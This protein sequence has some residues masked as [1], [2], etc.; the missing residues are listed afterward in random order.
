MNGLADGHASSTA[1]KTHHPGSIVRVTLI[2]FV[3]YTK[4]EFN[5]G[6]NLNMVIGPNGTGKST[7]VCAICIGLGWA[8]KHLGR[9][10]DLDEFVKHGANKAQIEIELA[11]DPERHDRNPVI[12]TK[13][14]KG[15]TT[16]AEYLINGK[17]ENKKRVIE[18]ARSFSIQ[19]DNLCQFLPQDRVSEFAGLS[20]VELLTETQRAAAPEY[21]TEWHEQLKEWRKAQKTQQAEQQRLTEDIKKQEDRQRLQEA[22]VQ[23]LR[24]R[25]GLQDRVN[26]L[27]KMRALPEYRETKEA[28][29]TAK[30]ARSQAHSEL[31]RLEQRMQ[32]NLEAVT[33]KQR[34]REL[35]QKVLPSQ[36]R[37]VE[38]TEGRAD[39]AKKKIDEADE[40]MKECKDRIEAERT[41]VRAVKQSMPGLQRNV[42][43]IQ[44]ALQNPP[45]AFDPTAM[46]EEKRA[47]ERQ[48]RDVND[49][50]QEA[51][52]E[53]D[54]L[55]QQMRQRTAIV[56][57]AKQ[58]KLDL[59]SQA[60]KN[61]NKVKSFSPDSA[62]AWEWIQN[63]RNRFRGEVY[64][65]PLVECRVKDPKF[66][67]AVES[68]I[69]QA[70]ALSFTVTTKADFDMLTEQLYRTLRLNQVSIRASLTGLDTYRAPMPTE[71]LRQYGLQG[72]ILDLLEGPEPVLAMLCDNRMI[73]KAAYTL[74]K[75]SEAQF[76]ALQQSQINSWVT[77]Q[78]SYVIT[79][80]REYGD[81]ATSTRVQD[82]R[83]A[84]FF[85][86]ITIDHQQESVIDRRIAE[87]QSEIDELGQSRLA[88]IKDAETLQSQIKG[89]TEERDAIEKEKRA[90][91]T[92]HTQFGALPTKLENAK[93]K[94]TEARNKMAGF[95]ERKA[96][97]E[98][99]ED[100]LSLQKGQFA[101]DYANL[102]ETLRGLH[103]QVFEAEIVQ[104][105]ADS[106]LEQIRAQ[107]AEE[108]RLLN[109]KKAE[110]ERLRTRERELL[111]AGQ[112]L[113]QQCNDMQTDFTDEERAIW[114]E[115]EEWTLEQW[116]TEVVSVNARLESLV[117]GGNQNTL[118]EFEARKAQIE[119]M[120]RK[121]NELG[122][123][124]EE[125]DVQ[126]TD[127]RERWEPEL[128]A[129]VGEISEAFAENFSKIQSAGEVGVYKAEDFEDW[130]I[131]IQVKFRYVSKPFHIPT[132][133][134]PTNTPLTEKTNR[135][136]SS[137]P[138]ANPA[139]SAPSAPSSTSWRCKRS[140]ARPSASS[141]RS[142]RAWT[143]ATSASCTRAWSTSRARRPA[144]AGRAAST[145]SSRPN[146]CRGSSITRI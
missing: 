7:L 133:S 103:L 86:D 46:N 56:Q 120:T 113:R 48:I 37:L 79:R 124:L 115:I 141:T 18:L 32:P 70:D 138:T 8:T 97:I 98:R 100:A 111:R 14:K 58:Q 142:T 65:P 101:L 129:L 139:A 30:N 41:S 63:N 109:E 12:T 128:D 116:Q 22:D 29:E 19:V 69:P 20:P 92:A 3:T 2:D 11:A 76:N 105:E 93:E 47:K 34:Y 110:V 126:I 89:L 146:C 75:I 145:S 85:T 72:W 132:D 104:I 123:K 9:G 42:N 88:K 96:T 117:G 28:W 62:K 80:R 130:A 95:A 71:S 53:V 45:A 131:H 119:A 136:P 77:A 125:L 84:R 67:S 144:M 24:E 51:R 134:S 91:Q 135:S 60:G 13:I 55:N 143:R 102:V 137:T 52:E 21:M 25:A 6:P 49:Q 94:L 31:T 114:D 57:E 106:E 108:E 66:A 64:G 17:K 140:R 36:R 23:R 78:Q 39:A 27:E 87:T 81:Q 54:S 44:K 118:R 40:Q 107:H 127:V 1:P 59:N 83:P 121:F 26:A 15:D 38:R 16:N 112:R 82:L 74:G 35:I 50:I 90:K 33:Q 99:E 4:A 61:L 73:H 10:K 5:P 43:E 68:M 122:S